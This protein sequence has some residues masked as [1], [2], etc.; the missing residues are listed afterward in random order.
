MLRRRIGLEQLS[1]GVYVDVR[2]FACGASDNFIDPVE[3][4]RRELTQVK[5]TADAKRQ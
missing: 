1:I 2:V 3:S 5:A 4:R